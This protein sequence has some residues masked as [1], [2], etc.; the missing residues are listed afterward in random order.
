MSP[1][2]MKKRKKGNHTG[3]KAWKWALRNNVIQNYDTVIDGGACKGE[4]TVKLARHFDRVIAF[5]PCEESRGILR[6][7]TA[8]LKN[9]EIMDCALMDKA[10]SVE[11]V[12]PPKRTTLTARQVRVVEASAT[13]G[14]SLDGFAFYGI[15][16]IKLDLEGAEPLALLGARET[17]ARAHPVLI[18]EFNHRL[19]RFGYSED[20]TMRIIEKMGYRHIKTIEVDRVFVPA[21]H[22]MGQ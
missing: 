6:E 5:E 7:R 13:W 22:G 16:L 8:G 18:V 2:K 1:F 17:I 11:V 21:N 20:D 10:C 15:G 3:T 19:Q 9:V 14:C 12:A 4:W